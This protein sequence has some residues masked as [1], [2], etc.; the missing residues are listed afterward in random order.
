MSAP[1]RHTFRYVCARCGLG[2]ELG[3]AS[4]FRESD[5]LEIWHERMAFEQEAR[6]LRRA[7]EEECRA[8]AQTKRSLGRAR[9]ELQY[10]EEYCGDNF[11]IAMEDCRAPTARHAR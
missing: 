7:L 1:R 9:F 6:T 8:H 5:F 10:A 11:Q 2:V 3:R 4:W